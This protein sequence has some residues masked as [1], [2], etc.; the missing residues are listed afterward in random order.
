MFSRPSTL[1]SSRE[2]RD[3]FTQAA[4]VSDEALAS[5]LSVLALGATGKVIAKFQGYVDKAMKHRHWKGPLLSSIYGNMFF[6]IHCCYAMA[7][8]MGVKLTANGEIPDD[9]GGTVTVVLFSAII[10][11]SSMGILA[12]NIPDMIKAGSASES[13]SRVLSIGVSQRKGHGDGQ[14]RDLMTRPPRSSSLEVPE[15]YS[16]DGHIELYNVS[17]A[18]PTRSTMQVLKDVTL[19][20]PAHQMTA[21]VGP[22]G[23]GKSTMIALLERWYDLGS[24]TITL[25]GRPASSFDSR[26]WRRNI[27]LVQQDPVLFDDTIMQ[28]VLNGHNGGNVSSL[29]A[30]EQE[31]LVVEACKQANAHDF[32]T[33]LPDGYLTRLGERATLIS[34]GQKQRI[35]IARAIVSNP[36][37]LLL[38]EVTSSLDGVSEKAVQAALDKAARGRT[39]VSIT[40]RLATI[41]NA[42]KIVVMDSGRVVEEGTHDELSKRGGMYVQLLRAQNSAPAGDDEQ[43]LVAA[44]TGVGGDGSI[45]ANFQTSLTDVPAKE[46]KLL[47]GAVLSSEISRRHNVMWLGWQMLMHYSYMIPPFVMALLV[48]FV[49]A[50]AFPVA[51]FLFS[52]FVTVFQLQVTDPGNFIPRGNFWALMFFFLALSELFS[53]GVTF[54]FLGLSNVKLARRMRPSYFAA[55]LKQD[56]SFFHIPG[57]SSGTLGALLFEDPESFEGLMGQS[58]GLLHIYL[59]DIISCFVLS[60]AI[61]WKLGLVAIFGGFPVIMF[62]GITKVKMDMRAHARCEGNFLEAA[63]FG[64]EAIGNIRTVSALG[65]ER[66][67]IARYAG[68]LDTAIGRDRLWGLA[69]FLLYAFS[70]SVDLLVMAL[71]FW[72]GGTLLADGEVSASDYFIVYAAIFFGGQAA[73]FALG[74]SKS[75]TKAQT[76]GNRIVHLLDSEPDINSTTGKDPGLLAGKDGVT[77]MGIE[78]EDVSFRYPSRLKVPVLR[79]LSIAISQGSSVCLVG[80]SGCGKSTIL[81]LVE[82]FF[83]PIKGAVK[84]R[85]HDL[86]SLDVERWRASCAFV[87]QETVLYSGTIKDNLL[88]GVG[89]E[90]DDDGLGQMAAKAANTTGSEGSMVVAREAMEM[91]CRDVNMHDFIL[92]LPEGY[93]THIGPKGASLSG[94]QRQR[95]SVARA[96][97]RMRHSR[98]PRDR[99]STTSTSEGRGGLLLLDEATS[100]LDA[101][102]ERIVG[103]ALTRTAK[104]MGYTVLAATHHVEAMKRADEVMVM[105]R[106]RVVERGKFKDLILREGGWLWRLK[107]EGEM[108]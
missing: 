65:L 24:G 34:G 82:R 17:F 12:P 36:K 48:G 103:D 100:A 96:L 57:H 30:E 26:E 50:A 66:Q 3:I 46:G 104:E 22:S 84:Y 83:D 21:I 81:S 61:Y 106:G 89:E 37:V 91:A 76:A 74:Y 4:V 62:A 28:N 70:D 53:Y 19:S 1:S 44:K 18:Y 102:N 33:D 41:R 51:A 64:G 39:T 10:A 2:P 97:L 75:L 86:K 108:K 32:I 95:L 11:S 99:D 58:V 8:Y 15:K 73:A 88:I 14:R 25:D 9:S 52:K 93:E 13:V 38:D 107:G 45:L 47:P 7:L 92:S 29:P 42:A 68:R 6:A 31:R 23:S 105:D 49:A 77:K 27:G 43:E 94:G 78:F 71:I 79:G 20:M 5:P 69:Y 56:A 54:Y 87:G 35:A 101:E 59:W 72:Y 90:A 40:H 98:Q 63:R 85:G 80:K 55:I 16:G 67:V 60:L